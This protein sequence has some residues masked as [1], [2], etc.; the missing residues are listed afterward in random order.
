MH[1]EPR[2]GANI[3]KTGVTAGWGLETVT[4]SGAGGDCVGLRPADATMVVAF[5]SIGDIC[6]AIVII[7]L[8]CFGGEQRD[9]DGLISCL[10]GEPR[11]GAG[12]GKNRVTAGWRPETVTCSGAGGD[13]VGMRPADATMVVAFC[14]I[15]DICITIVVVFFVFFFFFLVCVLGFGCGIAANGKEVL[16]G[17]IVSNRR[18]LC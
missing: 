17:T 16:G 14:S 6:I 3:G 11:D 10:H 15:G 9:E 1:G 13:F 5:C 12:I 2:D 8:G 4:C 7:F 18:C